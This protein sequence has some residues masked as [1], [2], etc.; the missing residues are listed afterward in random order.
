MKG[1]AWR[2]QGH[3]G[4]GAVVSMRDAVNGAPRLRRVRSPDGAE[5]VIRDRRSRILRSLSSGSPKARPAASCGLQSTLQLLHHVVGQRLR[6]DLVGMVGV[7]RDPYP[8]L[9]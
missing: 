3:T 4:G 5:G 8:R 6:P 2:V 7:A 9:E 1:G